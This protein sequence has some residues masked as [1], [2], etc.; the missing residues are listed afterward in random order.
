MF[1][2]LLIGLVNRGSG[3]ESFS[4]LNSVPASGSAL[5]PRFSGSPGLLRVFRVRP[6]LGYRSEASRALIPFRNSESVDPIDPIP[7]HLHDTSPERRSRRRHIFIPLVVRKEFAFNV[8]KPF[9]V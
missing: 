6:S 7:S 1:L 4:S 9:Q 5:T 3:R 8:D 2:A